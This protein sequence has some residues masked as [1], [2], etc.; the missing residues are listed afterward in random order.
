M[1]RQAGSG[2]DADRPLCVYSGRG[3]AR[4]SQP[5]GSPQWMG[6]PRR[7]GRS[8]PQPI[9]SPPCG[10]IATQ[11]IATVD[12]IAAANRAAAV[13]RIAAADRADV[14]VGSPHPTGPPRFVDGRRAVH[15]WDRRIPR[16]DLLCRRNPGVWMVLGVASA[17]LGGASPQ[18]R[19]TSSR[20]RSPVALAKAWRGSEIARVYRTS[21][22]KTPT[23]GTLTASTRPEQAGD[24]TNLKLRSWPSV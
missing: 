9:M 4:V 17:K 7:A 12:G 21:L 20:P 5:T 11:S 8:R 16:A 6:L 23:R 24:D 14:V 18:H 1:Q 19:S 3:G 22:D 2:A 13:L 15:A 10:V